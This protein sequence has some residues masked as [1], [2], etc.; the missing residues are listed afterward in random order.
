MVRELAAEMG[1]E[2]AW[3]TGSLPQDRRRAEINRFKRDPACRLFL[4]TDSGSVG[5]NL[6]SRE[7]RRQ[8]RSAVEPGQAR[9]A[10]RAGLAQEPRR[11][12][13]R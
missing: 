6:Q 11:A 13:S 1:F 7:R 3:H 10:D 9:T 12:R 8:C 2:T 4:S 5:L